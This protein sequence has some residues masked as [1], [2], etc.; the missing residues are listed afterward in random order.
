MR[1][2]FRDEV[3]K[4]LIPRSIRLSEAPSFGLPVI[5]YDP[6]SKAAAAYRKFAR[7]FQRRSAAARSEK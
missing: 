2:H 3:Y 1:E 5:E 4:T 6:G 7:E